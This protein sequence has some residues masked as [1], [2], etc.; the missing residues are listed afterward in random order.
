M[1]LEVMPIFILQN[2][3]KA[4]DLGGNFNRQ[5]P[6]NTDEWILLVYIQGI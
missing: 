6:V 3:L 1:T 4:H 2:T 5:P